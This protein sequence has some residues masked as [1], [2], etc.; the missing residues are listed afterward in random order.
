M[1]ISVSVIIGRVQLCL[2]SEE[3]R[4]ERETRM[5]RQYLWTLYEKSICDKNTRKQ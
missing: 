2:L 5:G 4:E 3:N 1:L